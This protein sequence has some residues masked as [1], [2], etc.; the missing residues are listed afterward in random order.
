MKNLDKIHLVATGSVRT[1]PLSRLIISALNRQHPDENNR[2]FVVA[3]DEHFPKVNRSEPEEQDGQ[4]G[5]SQ[6]RHLHHLPLRPGVPE[7]W[8]LTPLFY[9]IVTI[10]SKLVYRGLLSLPM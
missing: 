5:G 3:S 7:G 4:P 6:H 1:E 8:Q 9:L 2:T 10:S